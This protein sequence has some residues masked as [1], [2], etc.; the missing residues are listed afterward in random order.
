MRPRET[1]APP[2]ICSGVPSDP[3][4][5]FV[6]SGSSTSLRISPRSACGRTMKNLPLSVPT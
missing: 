3:Q 2:R 1:A 5:L 6:L 4:Q